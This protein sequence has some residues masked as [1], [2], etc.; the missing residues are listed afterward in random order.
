VNGERNLDRAP[1][2]IYC[3]EKNFGWKRGA[4]FL[5]ASH[6]RRSAKFAEA[7]GQWYFKHGAL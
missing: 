4:I 2:I 3:S 5:T 6:R 1:S 7:D